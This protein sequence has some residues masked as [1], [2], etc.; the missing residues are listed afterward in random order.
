MGRTLQGFAA[1]SAKKEKEKHLLEHD[2][3]RK[4]KRIKDLTDELNK[5]KALKRDS[6]MKPAVGDQNERLCIEMQEKKRQHSI[7]QQDSNRLANL[8]H[9]LNV[10]DNELEP[11]SHMYES[12]I[13]I[14]GRKLSH[15]VF[16]NVI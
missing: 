1:D 10:N 14:L 13:Y 3:K 7:P 6:T 15:V 8:F 5:M 4:E 9:T 16:R 11:P 2:I 12:N